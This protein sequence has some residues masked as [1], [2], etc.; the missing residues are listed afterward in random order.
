MRRSMETRETAPQ[1][2][3]LAI[4][5]PDLTGDFLATVKLI[6]RYL[7]SAF[8]DEM[9]DKINPYIAENPKPK[10]GVHCYSLETDRLE[11]EP[12]R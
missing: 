6:Y 8:T 12:I 7:D 4:Y 5:Y 11:A 2:R 1:E 9:E 3:I 10:R